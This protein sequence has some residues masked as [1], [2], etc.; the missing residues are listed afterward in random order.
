MTDRP[1][2]ALFEERFPDEQAC[3]TH[4]RTER[5][6]PDGF[7][8]PRCK[9]TEHWGWISTRRLF[10]CYECGYQASVTSG[11]VLQDTK[12]PLRTWFRAAFLVLTTKKGMSTLELAR[13]VGVTPKTAWFLH[14]KIARSL[15]PVEARTLFGTTEIAHAVL[16]SREA[17]HR[18]TRDR[19]RARLETRE[20]GPGRL[21]LTRVREGSRPGSLPG[22][23]V[24]PKGERPPRSGLKVILRNL[25]CVLEGV[26]THWSS[27]RLQLFLDLFAYRFNW[28]RDLVGGF[29][30][31]LARLIDR[32]P[33]TYA[34]LRT[35]A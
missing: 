2:L 8:C 19:I 35:A 6:G 33:C 10:E 7:E 22:R 12:L 29:E 28:R 23:Q 9:E 20:G 4:L 3:W 27:R 32:G 26:H 1:S 24:R 5:W 16:G 13:K 14:H 31:G 17:G 34:Q 15:D 18:G 30:H 11:T 21:A 25:R